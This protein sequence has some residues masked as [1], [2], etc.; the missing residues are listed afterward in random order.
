MLRTSAIDFKKSLTMLLT[1]HFLTCSNMIWQAFR[2]WCETQGNG[3][4]MAFAGSSTWKKQ[5]KDGETRFQRRLMT[6]R[7]FQIFLAAAW[8]CWIWKPLLC[9][10]RIE[11]DRLLQEIAHL[12]LLSW[13]RLFAH[14]GSQ[15]SMQHHISA[16]SG[17]GAIE[18]CQLRPR[19]WSDC[20]AASSRPQIRWWKW[21]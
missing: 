7:I 3:R 1:G 5:N 18:L 6:L 12:V 21:D 8:F 10:S 4:K 16:I 9:Q 13:L 20:F 14:V 2:F 11:N 19:R 17:A 15:K